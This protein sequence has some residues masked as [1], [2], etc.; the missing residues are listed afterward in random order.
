MSV[1][2]LLFKQK[3]SYEMRS[4][5]CISDV[6]S[7]DLTDS[8]IENPL[9]LEIEQERLTSID[10]RLLRSMDDDRIVAVTDRDPFHQSLRAGR[11]QKLGHLGLADEVEPERWQ[12]AEGMDDT[13]RR[14][15][16]RGDIIRTMQRAFTEHGLQRAAADYAIAEPAQ[17]TP[18]VG[19]VVERG[20]SDEANDRHYLIVSAPDR[21]D[22]RR[23][24][25]G[26]DRK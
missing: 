16:E 1:V 23:V 3:T 13:L 18:I 8:E 24:G 7:S 9:A 17:M 20:L 19:R 25:K 11:L 2:V 5:D 22:A 10:R 12:L 4:S 26:G 6:C 14:M 15:G 21:S